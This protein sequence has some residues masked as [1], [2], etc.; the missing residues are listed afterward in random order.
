MLYMK[1]KKIL[2]V[3]Q[4]QQ[5]HI[6]NTDKFKRIQAECMFMLNLLNVMGR[7][8]SVKNHHL[9]KKKEHDVDE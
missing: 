7:F 8:Y 4:L 2:K 9:F 1:M 6:K 3:T 5:R